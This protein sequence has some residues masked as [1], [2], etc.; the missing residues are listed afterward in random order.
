MKCEKCNER[1]INFIYTANINGRTTLKKLCSECAVTDGL[2]LN[3]HTHTHTHK[4]EALPNV[5]TLFEDIHTRGF[6]A[7]P[8]AM[9]EL[10]KN[11]FAPADSRE[12]DISQDKIAD[13]RKLRE[14]AELRVKLEK[15]IGEENFESAVSIRDEIRSRERLN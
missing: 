8:P 10:S 15:A 2:L 7:P 4:K 1:T 12:L 9:A 6:I 11:R 5:F 3:T 14:L 13:L